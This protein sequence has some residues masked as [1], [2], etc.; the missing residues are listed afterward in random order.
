MAKNPLYHGHPAC[1][2]CGSLDTESGFDEVTCLRCGRLTSIIDGTVVPL[3]VQYAPK[4]Q[5]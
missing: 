5:G 4:N 3:E 1:G 2:E